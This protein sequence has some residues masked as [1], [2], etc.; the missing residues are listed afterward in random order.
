MRSKGGKPLLVLEP[1]MM[2][3]DPCIHLGMRA[4]MT[5]EDDSGQTVTVWSDERE[6]ASFTGGARFKLVVGHARRQIG[7]LFDDFRDK[8]E[9]AIA[10]PQFP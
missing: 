2:F 10:A 4:A 8:Y 6:L 9:T 7:R 5:V 3:H 1:T